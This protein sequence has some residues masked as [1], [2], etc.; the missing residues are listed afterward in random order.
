MTFTQA[1]ETL[2][3]FSSS[4][5]VA[6]EVYPQRVY[7]LLKQQGFHPDRLAYIHVAGSKGKGSLSRTA[8][9][10]LALENFK[11]GLFVS[12]HILDIR[13]R[14]ETPEGLI[15][16]E[17]FISLVRRFHSLFQQEHLH[18]FEALLFMALVFFMEQGCTHAVLEV[19]VGGRFDPTNFCTPRLIL[20]AHISMEHREFLGGSLESIAWNKAGV[21]KDDCPIWSVAQQPLTKAILE[22]EKK[23]IVFADEALRFENIKRKP[24][25]TVAD[26][27]F[28]YKEKTM[29]VQG[30]EL[31]RLGA[32]ALEN[33]FLAVAGVWSIFPLLAEKTIMRVAGEEIP[34]RLQLRSDFVLAD[35]AHNGQSFSNLCDTVEK[36]LIW[37]NTTLYISLLEGKEYQDIAIILHRYA[38]LWKSIKVFDFISGTTR[39]SNG[40]EFFNMLEGLPVEYVGVL[41]TSHKFE[42]NTP[43]VWA[44]SFYS[45][46]QLEAILIN[47]KLSPEKT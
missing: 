1:Q 35:T 30:V 32:A 12:P 11:V 41:S 16:E 22:K 38:H 4:P 2:Y 19:G 14:I 7:N 25:G 27:A 34:Y 13:E 37:S 31:R 10:L 21:L 18:F 40:K 8:F 9:R 33:F 24:W 28:S 26:V 3:A 29:R 15:P 36:W 44:G 6:P 39:S 17:D 45:I 23:E 43:I 46:T 42:A 5:R 47:S 20:M